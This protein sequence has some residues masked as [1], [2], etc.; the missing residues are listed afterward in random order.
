MSR[1]EQGTLRGCCLQLRRRVNIVHTVKA[2]AGVRAATAGLKNMSN[3]GPYVEYDDT[4]PPFG[5]AY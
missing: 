5:S 4:S 2:Y 1:S 3:V